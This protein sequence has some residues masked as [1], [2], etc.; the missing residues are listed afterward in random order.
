ML[1]YS[2]NRFEARLIFITFGDIMIP[3]KDEMVVREK[4]SKEISYK[5]HDVI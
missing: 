1:S 4:S 3:G 5:I 2:L